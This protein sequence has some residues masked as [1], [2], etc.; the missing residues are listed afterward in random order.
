MAQKFSESTDGIQPSLSLFEAPT[1]DIGI[2]NVEFREFRS[3]G[4]LSKN[5]PVDFIIPATS[6]DYIDLKRTRI[7]IR[8]R[9]VRLDD[10]NWTPEDNQM[11]LVNNS[12]H[13]IFRQVEL[14]IQ[15]HNV[16]TSVGSNH[17]YKAY[18]D[19]LLNQQDNIPYESQLFVKDRQPMDG[20]DGYQSNNTG[21][22]T[23]GMMTLNGDEFEMEGPLFL[24]LCQQDR[25]LLNGVP[26]TLKC[27]PSN[28]AF[29]LMTPDERLNH[30]VEIREAVLKVCLVKVDPAISVAHGEA[31]KSRPAIYPYTR[32]AINTYNIPSGSYS[33]SMDDL[34]QGDVPG[35]LFISLVTSSAYN[36]SHKENPYNFK[37]FNCNEA[38][39]TVDGSSFPHQPYHCKAHKNGQQVA[40]YLVLRQE[41]G[42][43]TAET[44]IS[45]SEFTRGYAIYVFDTDS[46]HCK[47]FGCT[48]LSRKGHTRLTLKF[49]EPLTVPVTVIAYGKFPATLEIDRSRSV[50][51]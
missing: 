36:G 18:L 4:V 34:F 41:Q 7:Y 39:F 20:T 22:K 15:Q 24:D 35:K 33:F 1:S 28:D 9:V 21:L 51:V 3:T 11:A 26:L 48:T 25:M 47:L 49:S 30:H 13:S 19:T 46:Q 40:P 6:A 23:R 29:A 37:L 42:T 17:A 31:L 27:Y 12:L 8:A 43:A 16:S 45:R 10:G 50:I 5:S 2:Q 44:I 38:S 14:Y 32:S